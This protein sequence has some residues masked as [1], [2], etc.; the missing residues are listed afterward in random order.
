MVEVE[1]EEVVVV[2]VMVEVEVV[3][4]VMVVVVVVVVV[5]LEHL[6]IFL[7]NIFLMGEGKQLKEIQILYLRK[8]PSAKY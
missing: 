3:M 6:N 1:V 8:Y 2:M 7:M 4:V 5:G